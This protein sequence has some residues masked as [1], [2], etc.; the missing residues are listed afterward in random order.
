MRVF[1]HIRIQDVLIHDREGDEVADIDAAREL[2]LETL[3]DMHR[4]PHVYG[5]P[6]RWNERHFVLTD[7]NETTLLEIPFAGTVKNGAR[8]GRPTDF[9]A[10]AR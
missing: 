5:E 1:F 8:P 9:P 6:G 7:E 10:R 2:A 3:R 4:L